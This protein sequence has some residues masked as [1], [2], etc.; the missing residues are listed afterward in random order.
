MASCALTIGI[1]VA[2]GCR[3]IFLLGSKEAG[4]FVVNFNFVATTST[5]LLAL[6]EFA[7]LDCSVLLMVVGKTSACE[8]LKTKSLLSIRS[9]MVASI[10]LFS[11][12]F[13][14]YV[15]VVPSAIKPRV[16]GLI[17]KVKEFATISLA[18]V[19]C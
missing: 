16:A 8:T 9:T 2:S 14:L 12:I 19:N 15:L 13:N 7:L 11:Q 4:G 6:P 18:G 10:E 3:L 5:L 17:L 1:A